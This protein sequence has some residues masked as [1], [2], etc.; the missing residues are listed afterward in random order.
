MFETHILMRNMR[1]NHHMLL[2]FKWLIQIPVEDWMKSNRYMLCHLFILHKYLIE[3]DTETVTP[4]E[5]VEAVPPPEMANAPSTA[6]PVLAVDAKSV[7]EEVV[8]ITGA[9][10][11]TRLRRLRAPS[12]KVRKLLLLKK[13]ARTARKR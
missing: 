2:Q 13:M 5:D 6:N 1:F 11:R 12:P 10:T 7:K 3:T 4:K 8:D 9:P